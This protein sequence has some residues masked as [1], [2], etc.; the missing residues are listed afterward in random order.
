[1]SLRKSDGPLPAK[2][3]GLSC[4]A[5]A[6]GSCIASFTEGGAIPCVSRAELVGL[7]A[8][9]SRWD[10]FRRTVQFF[11]AGRL[12][13]ISVRVGDRLAMSALKYTAS[14]SHVHGSDKTALD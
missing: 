14:S 12:V 13:A 11:G 1:M 3:S 2:V 6:H 7:L 4:A 10:P 9:R 5:C 8:R